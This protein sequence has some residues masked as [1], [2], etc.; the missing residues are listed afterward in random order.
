[1]LHHGLSHLVPE[2]VRVFG[3]VGDSAARQHGQLATNVG[4][5]GEHKTGVGDEGEC[6][7]W[8]DWQEIKQHTDVG[9]EVRHGKVK[10]HAVRQ[11]EGCYVCRI[12]DT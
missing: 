10:A 12:C 3:A 11:Q 8:D 9:V 4:Q 6:C 5:Q 1:M 7:D 2:R